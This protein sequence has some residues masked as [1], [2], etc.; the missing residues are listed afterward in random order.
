MIQKIMY[1]KLVLELEPGEVEAFYISMRNAFANED[2]DDYTDMKE[3]FNFISD[4][5]IELL[6][7]GVK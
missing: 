7:N 4:G 3:L 1:G 5:Y 2:L 6:R